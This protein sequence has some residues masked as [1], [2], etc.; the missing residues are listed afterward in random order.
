MC[1]C[2]AGGTSSYWRF[3]R[4]LRGLHNRTTACRLRDRGGGAATM[5]EMEEEEE[6]E[7]AAAFSSHAATPPLKHP[8][9]LIHLSPDDAH[10]CSAQPLA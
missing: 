6:E 8:S 4:G 1:V 10:S 3:N 7:D 5:H 9:T 2:A